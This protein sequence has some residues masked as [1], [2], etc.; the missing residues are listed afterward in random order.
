MKPSDKLKKLSQQTQRFVEK[1]ADRFDFLLTDIPN[2]IRIRTRLGKGVSGPGAKLEK[3]KPLTPKYVQY[4][5]DNKGDLKETTPKRSGL[6]ATGQMLESIKGTRKGTTFSFFFE[7]KRSKELGGRPSRL[8][9][10]EV[11]GYAGKL[12]P[13]FFLSKPEMNN[14]IRKVKD[15][16]NVRIKKLFD[17]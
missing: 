17:A 11:A 16:I 15:E 5:K 9:N 3:L 14:L 6:T 2:Q 12:R 13:F 4:R 7:G 8:T 10:D 1:N